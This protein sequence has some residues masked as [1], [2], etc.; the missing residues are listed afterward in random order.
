MEISRFRGLG[1]SLLHV[2]FIH[3]TFVSLS[4]RRLLRG[5]YFLALARS[6]HA[7]CNFG[8]GVCG[9]GRG[10]RSRRDLFCTS[11]VNLPFVAHD[12]H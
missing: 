10:E 3:C 7:N 1:L 6:I 11:Q 9:V 8:I 12:M 5:F 2:A 4:A